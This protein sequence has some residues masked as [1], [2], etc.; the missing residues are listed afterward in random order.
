MKVLIT[1]ASGLLGREVYAAFRADTWEVT[2]LCFSRPT[3]GLVQ[4]DI[5]DKDA[6]VKLVKDLKPDLVIHSA[7][8]RF[9]DKM[10]TEL[11]KSWNLNVTSTQTLSQ[12]TSEVGGRLI[13]ISTDYV[14]DGTTPPYSTSSPTNPTNKYGLSKLEGENKIKEIE[15][16]IVLRI[17]VL[18]GAI[19]SLQESALTCL[20]DTVRGG[21]P[22]K[23][24]SY[25]VR[26]PAHTKDI[27]NILLDIGNRIQDIQGGVYQWS[28]LEKVTKWDI[29]QLLSKE[30]DVPILHLEEVQG[31]SP[32]APRPRDVEMERSKLQNLGIDHHTDFKTGFMAAIKPF[33]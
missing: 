11:E 14:F 32:G 30:L 13:Y 28:G 21:T 26:C 3:E 27:A 5:T 17:P 15:G 10:E 20:L 6:T 18:Y 4:H 25:E 29:V 9:P 19:N 2:G 1:G 31:P 8:Q 16:N 22:A 24:S 33:I 7:A 12:V 23:I